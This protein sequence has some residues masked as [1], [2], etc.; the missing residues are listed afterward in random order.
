M[1]IELHVTIN[2]REPRKEPHLLLNTF[3]FYTTQKCTLNNMGVFI[4]ES[5]R[6][7]SVSF[8]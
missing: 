4:L 2:T 8:G 3:S 7:E 6:P 1:K 5:G